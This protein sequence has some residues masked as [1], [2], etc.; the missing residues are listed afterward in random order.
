MCSRD[1]MGP[2]EYGAVQM[3]AV[4]CID[5][6]GCVG[7]VTD[8]GVSQGSCVTSDLVGAT[9]VDAPFHEGCHL[10]D[11][12]STVPEHLKARGGELSFDGHGAPATFCHQVATEPCVVRLGEAGPKGLTRRCHVCSGGDHQGALGAMVQPMRQP[13]GRL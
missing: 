8:N 4:A 12:P 10:V 3:D 7:G 11:G 6:L 13:R 9:C 1:R 2:S 5:R